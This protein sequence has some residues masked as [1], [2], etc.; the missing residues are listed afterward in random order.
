MYGRALS[1]SM[2]LLKD[3]LIIRADAQFLLLTHTN[4]N[5]ANTETNRYITYGYLNYNCLSPS[6][7]F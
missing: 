2:L 1:I 7:D 3:F 5:P 4:I 6:Q